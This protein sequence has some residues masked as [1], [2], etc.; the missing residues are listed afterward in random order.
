MNYVVAA[1]IL[2]W[3]L[4]GGYLMILGNRLRGL[5]RKMNE[6]ENPQVLQGDTE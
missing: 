2:G 1:Y 3:V 6:I 5:E 4:L